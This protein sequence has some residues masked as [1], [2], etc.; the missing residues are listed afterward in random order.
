MDGWE[1]D[2]LARQLSARADRRLVARTLAAGLAA[3]LGLYIEQPA[4]AKKHKKKK[5]TICHN[6][7]TIKVSKKSLK[8]H[9]ADGDTI[10]ACPST[11]TCTSG[12]TTCTAAQGGGCCD[13]DFPQ[14]CPPNRINRGGVCVIG[15]G[16]LRRRRR[17]RVFA[18]GRTTNAAR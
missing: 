12:Q 15:G 6:G 16:L 11:P 1:F 9:L 2:A 14:C 13:A 4:E 10:G 7:Q 18:R 8:A 17:G 3:T 5:I